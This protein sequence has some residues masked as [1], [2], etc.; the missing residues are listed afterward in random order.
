[1]VS[2]SFISPILANDK[3]YLFTRDQGAYVLSANEKMDEL[4][5]NVLGD[6]TI[7]NASPAASDGEL[8]IRSQ[9]YLYCL[10]KK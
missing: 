6:T 9:E 3:I 2:R 5:H 4:A 7:I 8:F 1:M 10:R